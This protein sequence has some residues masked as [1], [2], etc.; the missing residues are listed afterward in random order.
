MGALI[1]F[2]EAMITTLRGDS[3]LV[4]IM[5]GAVRIAD[6]PDPTIE[7]PLLT[8]GEDLQRQWTMKSETK[9]WQITPQIHAWSAER[10]WKQCKQI[11]DRVDVLLLD[12]Q[13]ELDP[14]SE[15]TII[16][17]GQRPNQLVYLAGGKEGT[18]EGKIRHIIARYIFWLSC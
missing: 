10:G 6:W 13:L 15:F 2:Q 5:L 11:I 17:K 12:Q 8:I 7:Y 14:S 1:D 9:N 3:E 18:D 4:N 16:G